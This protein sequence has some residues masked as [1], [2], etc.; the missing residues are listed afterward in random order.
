M[1]SVAEKANSRGTIP[2]ILKKNT[3]CPPPSGDL[4]GFGTAS[5]PWPAGQLSLQ[6]G[7]GHDAM[8]ASRLNTQISKFPIC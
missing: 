4:A 3:I 5:L 8:P 7:K 6:I 2:S 1:S